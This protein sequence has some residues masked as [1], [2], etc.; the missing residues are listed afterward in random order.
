MDSLSEVTLPS[1]FLCT[2]ENTESQKVEA[3]WFSELKCLPFPLPPNPIQSSYLKEKLPMI[4]RR[5]SPGLGVQS[6]DSSHLGGVVGQSL[7][8]GPQ[9]LHL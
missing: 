3:L 4:L 8:S 7:P 1:T 2:D 5:K 9:F 6:P